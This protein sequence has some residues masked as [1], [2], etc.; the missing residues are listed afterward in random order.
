MRCADS[1]GGHRQGSPA[2]RAWAEILT[3]SCGG[4][5]LAA[6]PNGG[7]PQLVATPNCGRPQLAAKHEFYLYELAD[8]PR[9]KKRWRC[10]GRARTKAATAGEDE[11]IADG[12]P[13][14][15]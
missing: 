11:M 10:R 3:S 12:V 7:R 9:R 5:Q 4:R 1:Q 6:H 13:A 15:E 2:Y 14:I 8:W